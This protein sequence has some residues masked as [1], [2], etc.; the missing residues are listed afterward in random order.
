MIKLSLISHLIVLI[1]PL[2]L[3]LDYSLCLEISV[4]LESLIIRYQGFLCNLPHNRHGPAKIKRI[5]T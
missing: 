2:D 5:L 1:A 3:L 4:P